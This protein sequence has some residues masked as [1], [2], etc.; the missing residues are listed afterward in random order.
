MKV[1]VPANLTAIG[2]AEETLRIPLG[3]LTTGAQACS[4]NMR[5]GCSAPHTADICTAQDPP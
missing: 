3:L 1:G 2:K 4:Q 5:E